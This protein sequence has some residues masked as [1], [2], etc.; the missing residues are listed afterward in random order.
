MTTVA[1]FTDYA[2]PWCYLGRARL[3]AAI[4]GTDAVIKVL[5]FP[6]ASDTPAEGRAMRP[7]LKSRGYDVDAAVAKLRDLLAVEGLPYLADASRMWGW[8]TRKAQELAAWAESKPGGSGVHDRLFHAYQVENVNVSDPEV[9]VG[10]AVELGLDGDEAREVLTTGAWGVE[11]DRHWAL[12]AKIG[13]RSVPTF[14]VGGQGLVGAQPVEALQR[15]L[16]PDA[17]LA[18]VR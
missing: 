16:A 9:L 4:A 13:V 15:L 12:G 2:C 5:H 14:V 1:M 10:L 11:V 7:Y 8:N 3:K 18:Q 17:P 6:L